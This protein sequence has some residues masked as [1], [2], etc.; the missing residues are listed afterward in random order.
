MES[1]ARSYFSKKYLSYYPPEKH[2]GIVAER[3]FEPIS[4]TRH[5]QNTSVGVEALRWSKYLK[6]VGS[7]ITLL[8]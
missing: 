8:I 3:L 4:W 2:G 1:A 7:L 5:G 6:P